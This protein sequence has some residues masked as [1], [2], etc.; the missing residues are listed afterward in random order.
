MTIYLR[1]QRGR[2]SADNEKKGKSRKVS[3]YLVYHSGGGKKREYEHLK[4]Y[5]Y[6]K[7][8]NTLE[9]DHN[10]ETLK[11][12]E[13]IKAKR[14]LDF[15]SSAHGF[16]SN[17][18]TKIS[19]LSFFKELTDKKFESNG[20]HGNWLSTYRHLHDFLKGK[21][22]PL[23]QID[24]RFLESFKEYLLTCKTRK[25]KRS[26]KLH[27]NSIL[28]YFSKVRAALREAYQSRIIKEN[29]STRVKHVKGSETHREFLTFEELQKLANTPCEL[30]IL[31]QAFL[32]SALTGLRFSD[33]KALRWENI[34]H[35]EVDGWN[36]QFTQ[37]KTKGA[38]SLP[39]NEQAIKLL[40]ER[41]E[42]D[43]QIFEALNYS[44]WNN[45]KLREWVM[46]AGIRKK[47]TFHCARHSFA[48]LQL[49]MNTD[50]YTVS[51][52]LGHRHLKTT[53]IYA[54]VIDKKKIE[55]AKRIP[56]L[57]FG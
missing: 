52:L 5:L 53:E 29:P 30:D 7:P 2:L 51:K 15:Q 6:D 23:D 3:L 37:K 48:T 35:S 8:R 42:P 31:K 9:K 14:I 1:K 25:G 24:D 19:F 50:I 33:V 4:L 11:L 34:K 26:V 40:G 55:A 27:Q 10:K 45:L 13:T 20:N 54:K 28:S 21:D 57:I 18:K 16:V 17:V 22:V 46:E 56:E 38:E 12:A 44:A 36:L 41:R 47:I 32:F 39:V 43:Q 49:S